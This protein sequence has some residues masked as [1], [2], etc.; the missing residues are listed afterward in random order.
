MIV[1]WSTCWLLA[2]NY[3]VGATE[4]WLEWPDGKGP[5]KPYHVVLLAGDEE[6]RSE[7]S[8]P[9]LAK[10]LHHHHG[11]RCTVL[12]PIDPD[13]GEIDPTNSASLPGSECL[14]S[15]DAV[16]MLLR[17]RSFP[18]AVMDRLSAAVQRDV[19]LIAL[20]TS[21]HAF[22]Y[23]ADSPLAKY[24]QFGKQVLGENWVSHWGGH[25]KEATRGV[26][27]AAHA[28]HPVLRGVRD[29]F[30]DTDVYEAY[31][32]ADAKVLL[33][34]EVVAGMDRDDPPAS[35]EKRRASDGQSQGVN[36]PMMPIAWTREFTNAGGGTN[37]VFC[38]TMG[39]AT[40]LL[41]EDLR[42][43]VVNAVYWGLD[44]EVPAHAAVELVG[45]FEAT[46]Y[47]FGDFRRGLQPADL[48]DDAATVKK[49]P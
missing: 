49:Q 11:F 39:A 4:S 18:A 48:A 37:R 23:P 24:N 41:C 31:P 42:R 9:M 14:E 43:L 30:G 19:P 46:A 10:I 5:G 40:D 47:G 44:L 17:F 22:K 21:T 35:Y 2:S 12:F 8:L 13:T 20:R 36:D 3:L 25:K 34:G 29:V 28:E 27:E 38:T 15:A 32:P 45:P 26:L 6:Y 1:G 16:V 33:R 7:E